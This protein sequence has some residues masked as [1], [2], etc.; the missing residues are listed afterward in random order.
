[1]KLRRLTLSFH[2][3]TDTEKSDDQFMK[4]RHQWNVSTKR[5]VSVYTAMASTGARGSHKE[6]SAVRSAQFELSRRGSFF[7]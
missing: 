5:K 7:F 6:V 2:N 3:I 4:I 1:M